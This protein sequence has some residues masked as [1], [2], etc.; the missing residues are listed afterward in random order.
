MRKLISLLVI[1]GTA[2]G[3]YLFFNK[4]DQSSKQAVDS[5]ESI[6]E[7]NPYASQSEN[8]LEDNKNPM[9]S[10]KNSAISKETSKE[11]K[12]TNEEKKPPLL[13]T[14]RDEIKQNPHV[15]PQSLIEYAQNIGKRME[16]ALSSNYNAINLFDELKECVESQDYQGSPSLQA[17]CISSAERLAQAHPEE[18]MGKYRAM[19]EKVPDDSAALM[20]AIDDLKPQDEGSDIDFDQ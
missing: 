2:Y 8:T 13:S 6:A 15:T 14:L 4:N 17:F 20:H 3:L 12:T 19:L 18:L 9:S 1:F 7:E 11:E 5:K 10:M 16:A